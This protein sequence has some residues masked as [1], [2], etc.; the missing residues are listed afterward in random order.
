ML[1]LV[2][3]AGAML[4]FEFA[5]VFLFLLFFLL[6]LLASEV[7]V[8]VVVVVVVLVLLLFLCPQVLKK[9]VTV[10]KRTIAKVYCTVFSSPVVQL[11]EISMR[12][13]GERDRAE[14]RKLIY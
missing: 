1:P 7:F 3:P 4:A 12:S 2:F 9:A 6:V 5:L 10:S 11:V 13:C 8:V 14:R